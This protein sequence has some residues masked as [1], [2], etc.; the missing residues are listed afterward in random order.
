MKLT[1]EKGTLHTELAAT[2]AHFEKNA[3]RLGMHPDELMNEFLHSNVAAPAESRDG[4]MQVLN[5]RKKVITG[6][7]VREYPSQL[8]VIR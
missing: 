6:D 3:T 2:L 4:R 8:S 5:F 7:V 1:R